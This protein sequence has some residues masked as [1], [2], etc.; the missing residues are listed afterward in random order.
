LSVE[1]NK[2]VLM[3]AAP[4]MQFSTKWKLQ[5]IIGISGCQVAER[6]NFFTIISVLY[7]NRLIEIKPLVGSIPSLRSSQESNQSRH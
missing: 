3:S 5:F 1:D 2:R 6:I 4:C 7:Q